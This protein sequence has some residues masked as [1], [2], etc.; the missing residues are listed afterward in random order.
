ML[1]LAAVAF[2]TSYAALLAVGW[3]RFAAILPYHLPA[4]ASIVLLVRL[5]PGSAGRDRAGLI[6]LAGMVVAWD[7]ADWVFSL[8]QAFTGEDPGFP[9]VA[10]LFYYVGYGFAFAAV[11]LLSLPPS[12]LRDRRWALDA[13]IGALVLT[14]IG[15]EYLVAPRTDAIG[16]HGWGAA[17]GFGYPVLDTGMLICLA[18]TWYLSGGGLSARGRVLLPALAIFFLTDALYTASL[19][20]D[21]AEGS[22]KWLDLGWLAVNCM[23]AICIATPAGQLGPA[24]QAP[25]TRILLSDVVP[26][27]LA[28]P[29]VLLQVTRPRG[30]STPVIEVC[31]V[32]VVIL[33]FARQLLTLSE[34]RALTQRLRGEAARQ[35]KLAAALGDSERFNG[36]ILASMGEGLAVFDRALRPLVFNPSMETLTGLCAHAVLGRPLAESPLDW[37]S[38]GLADRLRAALDGAVSVVPDTAIPAAGPGERTIAGHVGP[39]R[40]E[41]GGIVG[42]VAV[43]QDVGPQRRV[44][45]ALAEAQRMDSLGVLAGGVAHD[46]NNLLT[47]ILGNCSMLK[48]E[49]D[50]HGDARQTI[51][52]IEEATHRGAA[53][54]GRLLSFARG[55]M[56]SFAPFDLAS[57]AVDAV[58]LARA[59]LPDGVRLSVNLPPEPLIVD[60]DHGQLEQVVLNLLLNARDALQGSGDLTLQVAREDG[61]AILRVRDDGLG[62]DEVTIERAFE[63][64]FTT[65]GVG[66][67]TGLGLSIAYGIVRHHRGTISLQSAHGEGTTVTIALPAAQ[68]PPPPSGTGRVLIVDDDTMVRRA[69]ADHVA[70]L[71]LIPVEVED[72]RAA[73]AAV[74]ARPEGF[75]CMLLDLVMPGIS[76]RETYH[77]LRP[78]APRLP[79]VLCSGYPLSRHTDPEMQQGIA[80]FLQKPFSR[81]QVA[82][83]LRA[84]G[85]P[86][87]AEAAKVPR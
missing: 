62:M 12:Q 53:I 4:L 10:E 1:S 47:T 55:G 18:S 13:A 2:L 31:T 46:F 42:A 69:L 33:V 66:A 20:G 45:R 65:K 63:P 43:L 39:L 7:L 29:L 34:N 6:A 68:L 85:V 11:P 3:D 74:A 37:E 24:P 19:A 56:T 41:D 82:A 78:L 48:C 14:A 50:S 54:S 32:T 22:V 83:A 58:A 35:A 76:G 84:A 81:D 79:V 44:E 71:G 28:L 64:F 77:A 36:T 57:V 51:E 61:R 21:V 80:A 30:F 23:V 5:L 8:S 17:L 73:I 40:T 25:R 87:P 15:W 38:C 9:S 26:Y 70:S 72:G 49:V 16:L 27:A 67:G 60:G 86:S 75:V 59:S 52:L